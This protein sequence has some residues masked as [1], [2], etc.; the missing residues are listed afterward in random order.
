MISYASHTVPCVS[1]ETLTVVHSYQQV[2]GQNALK[3]SRQDAL[4]STQM[5]TIVSSFLQLE[6]RLL[7]PLCSGN[8]SVTDERRQVVALAYLKENLV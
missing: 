3:R 2:A 6:M 7:G 4:V 5:L 1:L 8:F